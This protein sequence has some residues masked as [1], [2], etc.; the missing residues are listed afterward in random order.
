VSAHRDVVAGEKLDDLGL[1]AAA[2]ELHHLGATLLHQAHRVLE[3]EVPG[4]IAHEGEIRNEERPVEPA[5]YRGAVVGHVVHGD[6]DRGV[7]SLDHHAEGVP[8]QHHIDIRRIE[9]HRETRVIT[10][11]AGDLLAI[12]LHAG[13][14]RECDR[15]AALVALQMGIHKLCQCSPAVRQRKK[16]R[17]RYI[18]RLRRGL[19]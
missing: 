16:L 9:Q 12:R 3:C 18:A 14:R 11:E 10:G 13:E 7:V 17:E 1:L 8:D 19:K 5:S 4:G 6:G 15:G 2:L